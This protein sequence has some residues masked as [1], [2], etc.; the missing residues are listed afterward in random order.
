MSG[1]LEATTLTGKDHYPRD[2]ETLLEVSHASAFGVISREKL[3]DPRTPDVAAS[4]GA[5][6][7]ARGKRPI[8]ACQSPALQPSKNS[9]LASGTHTRGHR[10]FGTRRWRSI[11]AGGVREDGPL[12]GAYGKRASEPP[13]DTA[14]SSVFRASPIPFT[15]RHWK[16]T[17]SKRFP[18]T[19]W[20]KMR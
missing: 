17:A 12:A 1:N 3:D 6:K 19:S 16:V 2:T 4:R 8:N 14:R 13:A 5:P 18:A 20:T 11:A 10:N 9:K 15:A 7:H